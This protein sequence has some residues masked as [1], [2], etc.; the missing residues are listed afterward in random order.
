MTRI[1]CGVDVSADTHDARIGRDGVW[2]RFAA[3][4]EGLD[5]LIDFCRDHQVDLVVLE[6][7][8]GYERQPFARLWA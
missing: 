5:A 2:H 1:I 8:G 6:A 4:A 7:S 3:T